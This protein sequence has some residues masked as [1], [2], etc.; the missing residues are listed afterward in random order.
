M[1]ASIDRSPYGTTADGKAVDQYTLTGAGGM[2]VQIIT[3]GGII[4]SLRV[5]DR[6]GVLGNVVLGHSTLAGYE[7]HGGYLGALIGRYGNRIG[8]AKFTLDGQTY[9]LA[10]NNGT[11]SLHGGAKG[12][13][14]AIWTAEPVPGDT[15]VGLK[16]TYLSPDGEENYPGNLSVTVIYTVTADN[17]LRIDYRAVTDKPTVVNL[18]QHTYFNLDGNG[19]GVVYD[20]VVAINADHYTPTDAGSIPTSEIAPVDGTPFDFRVPKAVGSDIRSNHPQIVA[21]LGFDHNWV[22]TRD[23][24]DP[25]PQPAAQVYAPRSGRRM[26]VLT[27]EP[28]V[29]FYT[30]NYLTGAFV[31]SSGGTYRQGD[32]LCLETQHFPDSPNQPHF[33]STRLEPGETYQSTTIFHFTTD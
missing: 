30:G 20:H 28:G 2:E 9:M 23:T 16:L 26:V 5:P 22:L 31:G 15:D 4:T 29:Q 17:A 27:T 12:F 25:S 21:A 33:P 32:G 11:A 10:V 3:Y 13:D 7:T 19:S 14:K 1:T 8:G 18:T 6:D 24:D